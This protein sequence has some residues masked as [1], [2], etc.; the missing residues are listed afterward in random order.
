MNFCYPYGHF[1]ASTADLVKRAGYRS[2]VT[3]LRGIARCGDDIFRL[4]RASI[5][6]DGSWIKFLLKVTTRYE[7]RYR[8]KV[9]I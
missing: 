1:N 5:H 8:R 3:S 2:A 4:P 7:D 6:G 9:P